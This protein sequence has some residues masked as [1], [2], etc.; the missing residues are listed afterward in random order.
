MGDVA[1]LSQR[2]RNVLAEIDE[3]GGDL[4]E[5]PEAKLEEFTKRLAARQS[6]AY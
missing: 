4:E 3:L 2:L 1:S 5:K 6:N